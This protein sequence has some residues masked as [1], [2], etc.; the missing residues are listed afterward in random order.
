M[1]AYNSFFAHLDEYEH[2]ERNALIIAAENIITAIEER[3]LPNGKQ[4]LI[5]NAGW[6]NF[7]EP[8]ARDF[9]FAINGLLELKEFDAAQQTLETF[10]EFQTPQG[11]FPIKVHSTGVI[12][13]TIYSRLRRPQ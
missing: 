8:W 7:R 13:R 9:G 10:L 1:P 6:R 3:R 12:E 4:K 5:L 2:E 11:Q